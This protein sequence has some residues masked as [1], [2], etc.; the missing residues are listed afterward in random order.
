MVGDLFCKLDSFSDYTTSWFAVA[1][2][3]QVLNIHFKDLSSNSSSLF[4]QDLCQMISLGDPLFPAG[5]IFEE[6]VIQI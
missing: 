6:M 5:R 2:S 1:C 4:H 3:P